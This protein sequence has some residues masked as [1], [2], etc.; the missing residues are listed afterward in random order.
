MEGKGEQEE[1]CKAVRNRGAGGREQEEARG[2]S[3][4]RGALLGPK[5]KRRLER[6]TTRYTGP[7]AARKQRSTGH[8]IRGHW[9]SSRIVIRQS[10]KPHNFHGPGHVNGEPGWR[11]VHLAM[12]ERKVEMRQSDCAC[13]WSVLPYLSQPCWSSTRRQNV[14]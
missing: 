9:A 6:V 13:S 8:L 14:R 5:E 1:D 2:P 11:P 7:A 3:G 10:A 4:T 12:T